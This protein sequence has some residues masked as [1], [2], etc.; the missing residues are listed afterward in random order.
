MDRKYLE[1]LITDLG[2]DGP[3]FAHNASIEI[4]ALSFLVKRK[5]CIDLIDTIENLQSRIIDTAKLFRENF[6]N[7]AI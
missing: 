7:V 5:N 2:T 3:I 6:Y 1:K 4:N